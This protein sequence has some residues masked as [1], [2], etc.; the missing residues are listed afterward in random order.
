MAE[1]GGPTTQS[2]IYYQNTI[3]ARYLGALLDLR[4]PSPAGASRLKSV[5]V[6]AP[7]HIDD[8]VVEFMDGHT[9]F[10][11]AKEAFATSGEVW[12]KFWA[13]T[14]RQAEDNPSADDE[15]RLVLG[16][17]S[18]PLLELKEALD[19]A[20]GKQTVQE[21]KSALNKAQNDLIRS[22]LD[23]V[24]KGEEPG[25]NIA[26]RIR[27]EFLPIA[28]AESVG[29]RDWMPRS[30]EEGPALFSHLR[31][32]CGGHARI[33][34]T[35]R[36][37]DLSELLLKKFSIRVQGT[38]GDELERYRIALGEKLNHIGVPGTSISASQNDLFVWPAIHEIDR[39]TRHDFED[40]DGRLEF[41]LRPKTVDFT[42]FPDSEL[43]M[44]VLESG[45]GHGKTTILR[46][47]ACR[48]AAST[49][50]VPA[51]F[52]AEDA[53]KYPSL[54]EYLETD[55]SSTY[56]LSVDWRGLCEQGRT[57]FL[58]DGI[59]EIADVARSKLGD[60]VGN[61]AALFP[62]TSFLVGARDS[63]IAH[64]PP[65]FRLLR[66]Q[67][68][69]SARINDM[70]NR[71]TH[72][73][74][75]NQRRDIAQHIENHPEFKQLCSVPLFLGIFAAT[76]PGKWPIPA[77]RTELLEHYLMHALSPE[78]HKGTSRSTLGK[79]DLRRGASVVAMLA[80]RSGR[81]AIHESTVRSALA[82]ALDSNADDCMDTLVQNGLLQRSQSKVTFLLP[83]VQEYLAGCS[84]RESGEISSIDL[85]QPLYQRSWAQS[86]LFAVEGLQNANE[87]LEAQLSKR[88]DVF[89]T[90]LRF[91]ARCI[92][93]GARVGNSL[94]EDV[95]DR[96]FAAMGRTP[97]QTDRR[98]GQL[99]IDGF[100]VP[101][102]PK[103]RNRLLSNAG[104]RFERPAILRRVN[105]RNLTLACLKAVVAQPDIRELNSQDWM[106][107][108]LPIASDVVYILTERARTHSEFW[109]DNVIAAI[110]FELRSI[111]LSWRAISEDSRLP[112]VVRAAAEFGATQV[113]PESPTLIELALAH[114]EH[115]YLWHGFQEAY[116]STLWWKDHL[117]GCC[118]LT[119]A[120]QKEPTTL[121]ALLR[122]DKIAPELLREFEVLALD[123]SIP[124]MQR[125]RI[126]AMLGGHSIGDF[127]QIATQY[128]ATAD[129]D[130]VDLWVWESS[131]F[132]EDQVLL[133]I[134]IMRG[135]D[136]DL[137]TQLRLIDNLAKCAMQIPSE[138]RVSPGPR[139]PFSRRDAPGVAA[140]ATLK[141][142]EHLFETNDL[143]S[144]T[145][146]RDLML[147]CANL[148]SQ[149]GL[150]ALNKVIE[151][152]LACND[153]ILEADWNW[154]AQSVYSIVDAGD[155]TGD[156][157]SRIWEIIDKGASHP[158]G[159]LLSQLID[160]TNA[161]NHTELLE[162]LSTGKSRDAKGSILGYFERQSE[163]Q[164]LRL[165]FE[166]GKYILTNMRQ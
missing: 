85:L 157:R 17:L 70:I 118:K 99:V 2:G 7:E 113:G 82:D 52:H 30:S 155:P 33:R 26:K 138:A 145:Q 37:G 56:G 129:I 162:Y 68:L 136:L 57:V 115:S 51:I 54:V 88:D 139:G 100:S 140:G 71:Y 148:R 27:V 69:D 94:K 122:E 58:I 18:G 65:K 45:A 20:R 98:I 105:D 111:K 22:M 166:G 12:E 5:R 110:L 156:I 147:T 123:L 16:S 25:F 78:R 44:V 50:Y 159:F 89:F 28:E 49:N 161:P 66:V 120:S 106:E 9:L 112:A 144:P 160:R 149:R 117:R 61:A 10:I 79:T 141:W 39:A 137:T 55:Y 31:D 1:A 97:H 109:S 158:V 21:W 83:T 42:K 142:A 62:Q 38:R 73:R 132:P 151:E 114:S 63:S 107:L 84:L 72:M 153:Q 40:E 19:R 108:F 15:F 119:V 163:R 124:S 91:V 47:T 93:N 95:A 150:Q 126:A 74:S 32:L 46:V 130:F 127:A 60:L 64:L 102:R 146:R 29:I 86:I 67:A 80:L 48:I 152:Y 81:S 104:A 4:L 3:G 133:G 36:A 103:L 135:R 14:A 53:W 87:V 23:A 90:G 128:L 143:L 24:G 131:Y 165:E 59:D 41:G 154:F 8:T 121:E 43:R 11:Q 116:L 6:E 134:E 77:S 92:A 101:L 76:L 34:Q 35:F 13:S 164:G 75:E 96:L 125:F